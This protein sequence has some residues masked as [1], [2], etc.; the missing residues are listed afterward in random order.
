MER[1]TIIIPVYNVENYIRKCAISLFSQQYD[2]IEFIFVNDCTPDNS[3]KALEETVNNF[4]ERIH[5]I[6]IINHNRNKGSAATRNSGLNVSTGQYVIFIDGDDYCEP[7]MINDMVYFMKENG[8]DT[9]V[10]DFYVNYSHKEYIKKQIP[11]KHGKQ[12]ISMVLQGILHASTCN[13]LLN[14]EIIDKNQIR[15]IE[16]LN[17]WEDLLFMVRYFFYAEN[18]VYTN[19]P[20]LHYVQ[21]N[22]S[23]TS[24]MSSK[25]LENLNGIVSEISSFLSDKRLYKQYSN[26]IMQ[27][28]NTVKFVWLQS[29][30]S[31][32]YNKLK[33]LYPESNKYIWRNKVFPIYYKIALVSVVNGYY[34]IAKSIVKLVGFIKENLR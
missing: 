9:V 16:G 26:D 14:K 30:S 6:K 27:L 7:N 29:I 5:Q 28:K 13:K 21:H 4:P 17:V 10:S 24:A 22:A 20:Y 33:N 15:F 32:N 19:K 8:A 25:S 34:L 23:Q 3:I 1:V 11:S 12:C 18:I 31:E 2:N